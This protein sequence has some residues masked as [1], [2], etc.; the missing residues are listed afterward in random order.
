[1]G[2]LTSVARTKKTGFT[3]IELLV[4][5]AIIAILI[6]LLLPAVQQAREAARRTQCK[7][8]LKQFGL[9]MHNYHDVTKNFPPGIVQPQVVGLW[10]NCTTMSNGQ[11]MPDTEN[12]AW[13][14][15]TM[16]LPYIDQAPLFN[17]L[18]PDACRMPNANASF[19]NGGTLTP[20]QSPLEVFRCPSDSGLPTNVYHQ[21]YTTSN[22]MISEQIGTAARGYNNATYGPNGNVKIRD[23]VDGTSNSLMIGERA[24]RT[25]P[26]GLRYS[27]GIVWGRSNASDAGFKFRSYGINFKPTVAANNGFG[28]DNGC[29]RHMSSSMHVG[30]AHFVMCDGAVRFINE[31]IAMNPA[32]YD[33]NTCNNGQGAPVVTSTAGPGWTFQNIYFINDA[34]PVG[35]F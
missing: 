2:A 21:S 14:W 35:E 5:I 26:A 18:K 12:R 29:I 10:Q 24:L 27:A 32:A 3:L 9:A 15:G 11:A 28:T 25:E 1:M 17:I 30:G 4:V 19:P 34:S 22:Y 23:I 7:N 13:G 20:L 8:N 6:A 31:N 33:P 16:L